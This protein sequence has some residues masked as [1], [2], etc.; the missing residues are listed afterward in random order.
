MPT[1]LYECPVHK[2]FEVQQSI[3]DPPLQECPTCKKEGL[4]SAPPKK[5][6]GLSS[7][8]LKGGCWAK[9]KYSKWNMPPKKGS[10]KNNKI[11]KAIKLL[12]FL[13]TIDDMEVIKVSLESVIDTLQE[14]DD[15]K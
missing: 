9:D 10:S 6:I 11:K 2:E 13:L 5:L 8:I 15:S 1:Y 4:K 12:K 14:A 3:K 7:F